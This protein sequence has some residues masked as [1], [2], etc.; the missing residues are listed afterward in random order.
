MVDAFEPAV[1]RGCISAGIASPGMIVPKY[2]VTGVGEFFG[3]YSQA[4]SGGEFFVAKSWHDDYATR[5]EHIA[6]QRSVY[7]ALQRLV[8]GSK[9]NR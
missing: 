8:I 2:G 9:P 6:D 3:E 5:I 7:P 4:P 1:D